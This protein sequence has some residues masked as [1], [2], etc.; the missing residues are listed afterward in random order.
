MSLPEED[1]RDR[2]WSAGFAGATLFLGEA[3]E[4]AVKVPSDICWRNDL[5][6][7]FGRGATPLFRL[8]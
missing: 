4:G 7:R 5:G 6:G 3:S 1:V 2:C 8:L